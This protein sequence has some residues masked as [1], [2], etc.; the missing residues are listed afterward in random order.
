[1]SSSE[2]RLRRRR[3][4]LLLAAALP[5]L[6][7]CGLR[8]VYGPQAQ[9]EV[10]PELAAIE[11]APQGG[12]LGVAFRNALI[13]ELNPS[14]VTVPPAYKLE[15]ELL[16]A[17]ADLMIQLNDTATRSNLILGAVFTLQRKADGQPLYSS[18]T[19][20]VASYNVRSDPFATLV[21]EQDAERRAARE[22]A[23]QIRTM[24]ALF[25]TERKA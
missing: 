25:L 21:A 13:D 15:V 16:V 4:G 12:A 10:V 9:A 3:L 7:A 6:G 22:V 17:Q 2:P 23:R 24:L 18:A 14:G 20:R 11:V 19:R 5:A 8:P 1:M